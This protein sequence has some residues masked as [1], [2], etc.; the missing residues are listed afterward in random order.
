M[1]IC[2]SKTKISNILNITEPFLFIDRIDSLILGQ[3]ATGH[4]KLSSEDWFFKSHLPKESAMPGTLLSEAMLQTLAT[5]IYSIEGHQGK[6]SFVTEI[7]TNFFLKVS[8]GEDL[9]IDAKLI[10]FKR[11]IARG[12]AT[13]MQ[14]VRKVC[15]G[16]FTYVSPHAIPHPR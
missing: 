3:S 11:G 1:G 16:E 6:P 4:M 2:L 14:G 15:S 7:K 8:P 12:Y 5:V 13:G 10:S 9:R